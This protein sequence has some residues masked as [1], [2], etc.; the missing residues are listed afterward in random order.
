MGDRFAHQGIAQ[1][2]AIVK[3]KEAGVEIAPV[4]NKSYRE[5]TTVKTN[6]E[7]V[8]VEADAAVSALNWGGP[9]FVDADHINL[10]NVDGFISS[11]D[12][13]TIDVAD[14]IGEA[15]NSDELDKFVQQQ[16]KY[17]G[18]LSIPNIDA[19]FEIDEAT[20]K[21]IGSK[22]LYAA[23]KAAEIYQH[24]ESKKGKGNFVTEVSMDETDTPQT[25][26]ELFFILSALSE[27]GIPAQTIAPKF[28]GRFNKGVDYV[29]DL[30][31]FTKEFNDDLAVIAFA[32]QEFNLP[33]NLKLSV[34]SGS[35]KFAIYKPI[36]EALKKFNAG[37]HLKTAGTTWLEELIGL[38]LAEGEGLEIAKEVYRTAYGRFDELCKPYATVIDIRK[39]N[40]PSPDD[41][42]NWSG[43]E[44]AESLRHEQSNSRYNSDFRQ[45]LH[46]GYKVAAEMGDRYL[47]ALKQYE[48]IVAEQVHANIFE[49]HVKRIFMD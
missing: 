21:E 30:E 22:Y 25:P 38:A 15:P 42:N 33:E 37:L 18:S 4:W 14:F 32:I 17:I 29:G 13:Y 19:S 28:T 27:A 1:L 40:L 10:S 3:A 39:D 45:L 41:V 48:S 2:T 43:Q 6:P 20:I 36:K 26:I 5:H 23:Q 35:D 46:V 44:Y 49:R 9:H 34:H 11:S 24:I 8:R 47:G 7:D 16:S 31:K 12:F